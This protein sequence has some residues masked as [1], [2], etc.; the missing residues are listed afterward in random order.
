M[1]SCSNK[2]NALRQLHLSETW[3]HLVEAAWGLDPQD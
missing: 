2:A 1:Y 3:M